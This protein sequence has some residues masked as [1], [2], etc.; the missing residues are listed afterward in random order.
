LTLP[1][2]IFPVIGDYSLSTFGV[3]V[4]VLI[5]EM[6]GQ[7]AGRRRM[8]PG[9]KCASRRASGGGTLSRRGHPRRAL[10]WRAMCQVTAGKDTPVVRVGV[11]GAKPLFMSIRLFYP[12]T[13]HL[14]AL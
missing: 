3:S 12:N 2:R 4:L 11:L 9:H 13:Y 14:C 8:E 7:F 1:R 5:S 10:P 6:L